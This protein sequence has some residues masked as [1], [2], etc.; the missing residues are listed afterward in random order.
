MGKRPHINRKSNNIPHNYQQNKQ[1][2]MEERA[3]TEVVQLMA[4]TGRRVE[5]VKV[6]FRALDNYLIK[7][8]SM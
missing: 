6:A 5:K 1:Q 2:E 7:V 4:Q 8:E 3:A